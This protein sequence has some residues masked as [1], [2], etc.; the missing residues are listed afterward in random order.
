MATLTGKNEVN[1]PEILLC[2]CI[3]KSF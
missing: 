3:S 2:A 1:M